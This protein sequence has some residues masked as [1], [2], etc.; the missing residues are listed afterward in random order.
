MTNVGESATELALLLDGDAPVVAPQLLNKVIV[1]D[2]DGW[3]TAG[4]I[5][6]VEAYTEDDPASHSSAG[7]TPR[8]SVMFGPS[9]RLYVY[10]SYGIHCCAN[11]V[12]GPAG[13]GQAVLLRALHPIMGHAVMEQRRGRRAN[14]ADGP[15]KLCQALAIRLDHRDVDLL[16]ARS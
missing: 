5:V 4:R 14:L 6:E 2:V 15:G 13:S 10:L 9:G 16:D 12:V 7:R 8:T 11:V 3:P 1:S